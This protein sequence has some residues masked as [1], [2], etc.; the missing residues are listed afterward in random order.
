MSRVEVRKE[1]EARVIAY[2]A[3]GQNAST[4]CAT[5]GVKPQR[6]WYWLRRFRSEGANVVEAVSSSPQWLPVKVGDPSTTGEDGLTIRVGQAAITV[7][8]GFDPVLLK[9]VVRT[10]TSLC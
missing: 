9:D 4:W 5:D 8:P 10:L 6:L 2:K 3:S 7:H 1:W